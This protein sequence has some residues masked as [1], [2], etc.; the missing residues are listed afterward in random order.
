[1]AKHTIVY[2]VSGHGYGHSIRSAEIMAQLL[3]VI[4]DCHIHVR[5][6]APSWLFAGLPSGSAEVAPVEFDSGVVEENSALTINPGATIERAMAFLRDSSS[7]VSSEVAFIRQSRGS[8]IVTD[9][10]YLAGNVA[11]EAGVPSMAVC[12]FT[13]DWIY[14]PYCQCRDSC[15]SLL[16]RIRD[17]YSRIHMCL[18][19]PF[20]HT[21]HTFPEAV[22][23]PLVARRSVRDRNEILRVAGLDARDT[24]PRVL[25]GMR[26]SVSQST[27]LSVAR[28]CGDF[29]FVVPEPT[30]GVPCENVHVVPVGRTLSFVDLL[31]VCDVVVCKLGYGILADSISCKTAVLFPPREGFREDEILHPEANRWARILEITQQDFRGGNWNPYLQNLIAMPM[32]REEPRLDGARVCAQ[33]IAT[34]ATDDYEGQ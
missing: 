33:L 8:L 30:T 34:R 16:E 21:F 2:Y 5:T 14:E 20:S 18:R 32:P 22:D 3:E 6:S 12:N 4:P 19:L 29:V 17:G 11:A 13:W 24:R 1:M 26:H 9:I 25:I 23:V 7:V 27:L 10:P 31:T 15:S 28:S